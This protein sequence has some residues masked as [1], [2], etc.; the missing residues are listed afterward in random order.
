MVSG[1]HF[2]A[3]ELACR[4]CG[5]RGAQQELVDALERTRAALGGHPIA[6][7]SAYR[8]PIHNLSLIHI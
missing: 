5:M 6:L 1:P 3:A 7:R 8:C 2:T 4:H